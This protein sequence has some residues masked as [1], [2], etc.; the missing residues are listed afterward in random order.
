[1][2]TEMSLLFPILPPPPALARLSI[3]RQ[4]GG[5]QRLIY[6]KQIK[7]VLQLPSCFLHDIVDNAKF[8]VWR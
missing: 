7:C 3:F 6:G 4:G 2:S 8:W 5:Y 1:M